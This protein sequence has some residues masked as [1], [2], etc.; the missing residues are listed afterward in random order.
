MLF[1]DVSNRYEQFGCVTIYNH[2]I[3]DFY[4]FIGY[5]YDVNV[6]RLDHT[7]NLTNLSI[8]NSGNLERVTISIG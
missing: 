8:F 4:F 7:L 2:Y 6:R 1:I 5:Y 3:L